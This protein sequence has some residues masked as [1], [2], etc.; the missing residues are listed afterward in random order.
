[1]GG[2]FKKKG[3]AG[4]QGD[5]RSQLFDSIARGQRETTTA[6]CRAHHEEI[7]GQW[8]GW[9]MQLMMLQG[10]PDKAKEYADQLR[11]IAVVMQEELGD[12]RF[13]NAFAQ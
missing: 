1:M 8:P 11:G 4:P 13:M 10:T 5:L 2:L 7:W 6:L 9:V 3:A 12:G